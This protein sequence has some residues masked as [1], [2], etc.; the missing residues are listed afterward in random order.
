MEEKLAVTADDTAPLELAETADEVLT[1]LYTIRSSLT[2]RT[3]SSPAWRGG[4]EGGK[5]HF[6]TGCTCG[7]F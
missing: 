2:L 3:A 1:Q 5:P 4:G 6:Y 7:H